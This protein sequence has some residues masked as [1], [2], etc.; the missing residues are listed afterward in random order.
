M[1]DALMLK[2]LTRC[3]LAEGQYTPG[4]LKLLLSA[5]VCL[6]AR[7]KA[8]N[9]IHIILNLYNQLNKFVVFKCWYGL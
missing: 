4:Y 1:L 3:T 2:Y 7:P 6:S 5:T 8:I 9:C